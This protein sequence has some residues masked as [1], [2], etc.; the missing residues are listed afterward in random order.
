MPSHFTAAEIAALPD[1]LSA[2]RFGTYVRADGHRLTT[3]EALRLYSWNAQI[4]AA[5][6]FPLHIF[7]VCIRNAVAEAIES[8]Y[9]P[10][11]PNA[12]SFV[13]S[14]PNPPQPAFS[15][16]REFLFTRAKHP[17]VGKMIADMKFAF[18][19]SMFTARH[20]DRLWAPSFEA[21]FPNHTAPSW[22]DGR[23][24]VHRTVDQ[25]RT[26]RNRIAHHEP[27]FTRPLKDE[28]AVVINVIG[29]RC[30]HTAAWVERSQGVVALLARK[31]IP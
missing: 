25:V 30:S 9:G 17:T 10:R 1:I 3:E 16:R 7:E 28:Y 31:P 14:L 26:L 19:V 8:Y 29:W 18:W 20:R 6:L 2:P 11:W 21:K 15:P 22:E 4:S 27:I 5:L 12:E 24:H 13:K 23:Q